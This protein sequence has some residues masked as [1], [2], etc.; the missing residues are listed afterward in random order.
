MKTEFEKMRSE[1]LYNFL[2]K[3]INMSLRNA[4]DLCTRLQVLTLSS[5]EYRDVIEK[6]IPNFPKSL[7]F[8][9]LFIATMVLE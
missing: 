5:S 3:E 8:V 4:K 2:D 1:E 9:L 6:L 7:G